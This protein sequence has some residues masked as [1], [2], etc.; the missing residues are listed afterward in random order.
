MEMIETGNNDNS[1]SSNS[2]NNSNSSNDKQHQTTPKSILQTLQILQKS[3]SE[4]HHQEKILA[5]REAIAQ[6]IKIDED[7]LQ[8][9]QIQIIQENAQIAER[10]R[11][12][13]ELAMNA[14]NARSERLL[15]IERR[16]MADEHLVQSIVKGEEGVK[17]QLKR[18]KDECRACPNGTDDSSSII[19]TVALKA[20]CT[21]F[22]QIKASPDILQFRRVRR[23]HPRFMS[24][25]GRHV[26][27]VQLLIAAGFRFKSVYGDGDGDGDGGGNSGDSGGD[28]GNNNN[29]DDGVQ[30]LILHEPNLE[31]DMDGWYAWFNLV[32]KTL[33]LIEAE[34]ASMGL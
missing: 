24:D 33:A 15:S 28:D 14:E 26:G 8:S 19:H 16:K 7:A 2:S 10:V 30:C 3:E 1:N 22:K 6:Q 27:G 21:I 31:H 32:E 34:I 13:N 12:E 4:Y 5:E 11:I 29:N 23:N 17:I 25:V 20:L 9:S 18:L